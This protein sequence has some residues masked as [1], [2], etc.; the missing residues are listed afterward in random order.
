ML[1]NPQGPHDPR[2]ISV[3]DLVLKPSFEERLL[4]KAAG[5]R[6]ILMGVGAMN[7]PRYKPAGLLIE[8]HG[9]RVMIDGGK[10]NAPA[11]SLD[12]WLTTDEHGELA[13]EL[14][15]FV[16]AEKGLKIFAG[17][18]HSVNPDG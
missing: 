7:S 12:A 2:F 13:S 3:Y 15:E 1:Y 11:G 10:E 17:N 4:V 6:L 16:A 8:Y 9:A 14:R 18:Y 5:L